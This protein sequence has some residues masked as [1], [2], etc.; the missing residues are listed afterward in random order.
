MKVGSG[1]INR[2]KLNFINVRIVEKS[3]LYRHT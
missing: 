3:G 2:K 1:L